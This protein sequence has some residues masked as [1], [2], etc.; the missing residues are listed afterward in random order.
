MGK[1]DLIVMN[2][3]I[4]GV[5]QILCIYHKQNWHWVMSIFLWTYYAPMHYG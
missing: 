1:Y 3:M 2:V 5:L 4:T